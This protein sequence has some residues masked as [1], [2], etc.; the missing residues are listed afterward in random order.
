MKNIVIIGGGTGTFTLLS[1]LRQFP[2]NNSVIV[3]TA[4]D[5]GS[6]GRLREDLGVIPPGDIRQCLVGLS[7]TDPEIQELFSYRFG[8]GELRG[9][10]IGNVI[11]AALQKLTGNVEQAIITA[12]KLLNVRGQVVPV[13]LFPTTLSAVYSNG[14]KVVGEHNIDEPPSPTLPTRG[15]ENKKNSS[16][17]LVGEARWGV[18]QS[19]KTMAL[20]PNGPA[21]P[22]ALRLISEADVIVFGPGD[23][24]TSTIP[25][26]LVK[27]MAERIRK[28]KAKKVLITNIMT[29]H[30]QTDGYKASDFVTSLEKYLGKGQIHNII[31][32]TEKPTA[33]WLARHRKER[34]GFVR[35]D[36]AMLQRMKIKVIAEPLLS[37]N[38]FQKNS[39]DIL[40]RSFLR[41]DS[42]KLARIIWQ[43]I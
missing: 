31:V 42:E 2:V 4:D 14:K 40:K 30:G 9:H 34:S 38:T 6:T 43:L 20:K 35:P 7:Y 39:S 17:P 32:N 18:G 36:T 11:L 25:N 22:R 16:S 19:I 10:T 24:Y 41:H 26:L 27:G 12:A 28:S 8:K 33:K 3:S 21:N 5:G 23:L 13:T 37:S 1:G 15:R 29:K